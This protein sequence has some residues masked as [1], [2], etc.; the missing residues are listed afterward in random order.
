VK[1]VL[2]YNAVAADV[3]HDYPSDV[4]KPSVAGHH[5]TKHLQDALLLLEVRTLTISFWAMA[6][7]KGRLQ[8]IFMYL[9]IEKH[10]DKINNK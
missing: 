1:T 4:A 6:N 9:V 2:I 5:I 3:A 8:P 7:P 10:A